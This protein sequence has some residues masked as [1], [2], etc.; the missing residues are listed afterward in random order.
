MKHATGRAAP[1]DADRFDKDDW[2][3]R[4]IRFLKACRGLLGTD[5]KLRRPYAELAGNSAR[6]SYRQMARSGLLPGPS[7]F[8][9]LEWNG[10]VAVS[11]ATEGFAVMPGEAIS[12]L[13]RL[14]DRGRC[15]GSLNYDSYDEAGNEGWWGQNGYRLR[16]VM[17]RAVRGGPFAL[18]LN[19][20]LDARFPSSGSTPSGRAAAH[21]DLIREHLTVPDGELASR[22]ALGKL[23]DPGF[24]GEIGGLEVYRS[25][26]LRM[27][28]SRHVFGARG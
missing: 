20:V 28:T 3:D 24:V 7:H 19:F 6:D 2:R 8:V 25:S 13:L 5:G 4:N 9:A 14:C 18:I 10:G 27:L 21:C 22:G 23:D 26:R 15:V 16:K 1:R 12:N 17:N 11:L